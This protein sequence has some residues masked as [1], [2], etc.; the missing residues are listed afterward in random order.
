MLYMLCLACW[1]T[2]PT[3]KRAGCI[4]IAMAAILRCKF[5]QFHFSR[6]L[7]G[8]YRQLAQCISSSMSWA[9]SAITLEGKITTFIKSCLSISRWL[10]LLWQCIKCTS[11]IDNYVCI[12]TII[13]N[14][15]LRW[16]GTQVHT[17]YTLLCLS[18][19]ETPIVTP[20]SSSG[21]ARST[22]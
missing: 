19:F 11:C 16:A 9:I 10:P 4:T 2:I 15:T 1:P 5:Y 3:C 8:E 20:L 14:L 13:L 18:F 7:S 22:W 21:C 17:T 12:Q 6:G